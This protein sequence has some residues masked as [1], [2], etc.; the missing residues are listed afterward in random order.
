LTD[1]I[2][3]GIMLLPQ[4]YGFGVSQDLRSDLTYPS[5][6]FGDKTLHLLQWIPNQPP[7]WFDYGPWIGMTG[8]SG[9]TGPPGENFNGVPIGPTGGFG[10]LG[11]TGATGI[12]GI[13][14]IPGTVGPFFGSLY[15]PGV[16]S[17]PPP[18]EDT[19]TI[20]TNTTLTGD[21]YARNLYITNGILRTNGYRIFVQ[22]NFQVSAP[23][24]IDNSGQ[25][26]NNAFIAGGVLTNPGGAG[27]AGGVF[28]PG[29]TGGWGT[30]DSLTSTGGDSPAALFLPDVPTGRYA[31]GDN[32][33]Q[34]PPAG[35]AGQVFAQ[36][37]VTRLEQLNAVMRPIKPVPHFA[38]SG[39]SGGGSG[40]STQVNIVAASGGGGGGVIA[41]MAGFFLPSSGL[42]T[43]V[44]GAGGNGLTTDDSPGGGGGGGLII[45]RSTSTGIATGFLRVD[46]GQGGIDVGGG[47]G[48]SS[49]GQPGQVI[50]LQ[51][52]N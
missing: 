52:N 41:I 13:Q 51:P 20:T 32:T 15:G 12:T 18:A 14:G 40:S 8:S 49:N 28:Y 16:V 43:A 21:F 26:G 36:D 42:I 33:S 24:S 22:N 37:D 25:N 38:I 30:N 45:I 1:A 10:P 23:G 44:G 3:T 48:I 19:I 5:T 7:K 17:N 11:Q 6:L 47:G 34:T 50:F 31:G 2:V 35:P 27:G 9:P 46:G 4:Q 39:G 29:G